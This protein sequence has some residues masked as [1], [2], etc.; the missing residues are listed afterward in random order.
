LKSFD[1]GFSIFFF[2]GKKIYLKC[3]KEDYSESTSEIEI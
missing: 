2:I 1:F 3:K